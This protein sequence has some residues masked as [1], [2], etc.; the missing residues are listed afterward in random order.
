M[1]YLKKMSAASMNVIPKGYREMEN[2]ATCD[3]FTV[4]GVAEEMETGQTQMG[5]YTAFIGS[6]QATK[7]DGEV[8]RSK[9]LFLPDLAADAVAD[10]L[11]T[12]GGGKVEFAFKIGMRRVVK[13][14]AQGEETGAGYEYTM[15]PL[16]EIDEASD[17]LAHLQNKIAA[18]PAP[19]EE[20][21]GKKSK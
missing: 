12:A 18:L 11:T 15:T 7:T 17:P 13:K 1:N 9:K 14:N 3:L 20:K 8:F 19:S 10:A 6:F 21:T 2:G 4:I 5:D 16:L